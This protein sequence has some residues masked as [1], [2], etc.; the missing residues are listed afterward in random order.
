MLIVGSGGTDMDLATCAI[1]TDDC[2]DV[3]M[4]ARRGFLAFPHNLAEDRPLDVFITNLF[5][6]SYEASLGPCASATVDSQHWGQSFVSLDDFFE[7]TQAVVFLS[8][9]QDSSRTDH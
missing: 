9:Q 6:H 1:Q 8:R 2:T 7:C 5:E 3:A 4:L